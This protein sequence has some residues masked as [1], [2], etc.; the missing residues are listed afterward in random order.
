[1]LTIKVL[2]LVQRDIQDKELTASCELIIDGTTVGISMWKSDYE[3]LCRAGFFG[4][5]HRKTKDGYMNGS[6]EYM[7]FT[8]AKNEIQG[9]EDMKRSFTDGLD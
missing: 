2:E 1:M 7:T 3:I 6:K 4:P 9:S 8:Q 5:G